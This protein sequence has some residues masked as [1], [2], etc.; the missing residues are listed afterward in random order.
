MQ[1]FFGR[2]ET[3]ANKKGIAKNQNS[4]HQ[5]AGTFFRLYFFLF[6]WSNGCKE[7]DKQACMIVFLEK[8]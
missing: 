6:E 8:L 5:Q 3:K 1:P 7:Q 2:R 4:S